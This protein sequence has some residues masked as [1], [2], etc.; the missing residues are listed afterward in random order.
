[1]KN[2][3][4]RLTTLIII[5]CFISC[6]AL[7]TKE[8]EI[9]NILQDSKISIENLDDSLFSKSD[10]FKD[11]TIVG[12]GEATHGSHELFKVRCQLTKSLIMSMNFKV[13]AIE[14][15]FQECANLNEYIS[16]GAG[17]VEKL[18]KDLHQWFWQREEML[19]FIEWL[20]H[21][22]EGKKEHEK[23]EI[24]GFDMQWRNASAKNITSF[25]SANNPSLYNKL[26]QQL[27]VIASTENT[28]LPDSIYG[29]LDIIENALIKNKG[30]YL[31]DS[32][33]Y[34]MAFQNL[35]ILKQAELFLKDRSEVRL[36]YEKMRE[37]YMA[38]NLIWKY[39]SQSQKIVLWA[40]NG[41]ISKGKR[42][43]L[44][45]I[46]CDELMGRFLKDKFGDYYLPVGFEF[47]KGTFWAFYNKEK[48]K[49][50]FLNESSAFSLPYFLAK[51]K[52][53]NCLINFDAIRSKGKVGKM[54]LNTPINSHSI[55]T[56]YLQND[57]FN[58]I[59]LGEHY[60][61]IIYIEE[62]SP[63]QFLNK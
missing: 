1:M 53:D 6:N 57:R 48:F 51:A 24:F 7:S 47:N 37:K 16:T 35:R 39:N 9:S 22:N 59:R 21:Y 17:D 5:I 11:K 23:V 2:Q 43:G 44:W 12:L 33:E 54:F 52:T 29:T 8:D 4:F 14:A 10:L 20:R 27:S 58:K 61:S 31:K 34:K 56:F 45:G 38:Q 49:S 19:K 55:G 62:S 15:G 30:N 40:H 26:S 18:I 28:S 36:Y 42:C 3:I 60:E 41:H 32:I 25:L 13:I 46:M 50:I 63:F